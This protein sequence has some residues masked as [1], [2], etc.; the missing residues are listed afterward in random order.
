MLDLAYLV[1]KGLSP[2]MLSSHDLAYHTMQLLIKYCIVKEHLI[3][4]SPQ[5]V[6]AIPPPQKENKIIIL[7]V[8]TSSTSNPLHVR[9][10]SPEL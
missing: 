4:I 6:A 7:C 10:Q 1:N 3:S 9:L 2:F 8:L 5:V